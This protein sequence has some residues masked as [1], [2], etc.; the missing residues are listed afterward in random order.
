VSEY[1]EFK[2]Y[3]ERLNLSYFVEQIPSE[4]ASSC[5]TWGSHS[6]VDKDSSLWEYEFSIA[7]WLLL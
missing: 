1:T 6:N 2:W 7:K 5:K 4:E 3:S